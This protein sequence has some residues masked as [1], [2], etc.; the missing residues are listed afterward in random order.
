MVSF[1][2]CKGLHLACLLSDLSV[3]RE[4]NKMKR[5]EKGEGLA[6]GKPY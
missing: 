5:M 2:Q 6:F 3:Y 1:D 4:L